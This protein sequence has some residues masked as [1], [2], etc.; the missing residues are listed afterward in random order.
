MTGTAERYLRSAS[1]AQR[2][3][4]L[5]WHRRGSIDVAGTQYNL[6]PMLDVEQIHR[7]LY[8]VRRLREE[9]GVDA[10]VAM[11]CDVNGLSWLYADLRGWPESPTSSVHLMRWVCGAR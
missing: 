4:F 11:Q 10:R 6:T 5:T 3:R 7:S 8:P 9:F 2:A 1:G